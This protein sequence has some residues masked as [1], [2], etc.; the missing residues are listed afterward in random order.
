ME[1]A[2]YLAALLFI[3]L[4]VDVLQIEVDLTLQVAE[5]EK[6]LAMGLPLCVG[7]M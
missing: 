4:H 2:V 7:L 6:D 5:T 3:E 1:V